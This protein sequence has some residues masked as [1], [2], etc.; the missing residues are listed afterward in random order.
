MADKIMGNLRNKTANA[1]KSST[2][3][4]GAND[5]TQGGFTSDMAKKTRSAP[6]TRNRDDGSMGMGGAFGFGMTQKTRRS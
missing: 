1:P 3:G 6:Q 2:A 5:P 4:T